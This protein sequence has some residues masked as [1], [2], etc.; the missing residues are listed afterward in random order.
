M[1]APIGETQ[2][3][4]GTPAISRQRQRVPRA[5]S[6][7][8]CLPSSAHDVFSNTTP[9]ASLPTISWGMLRRANLLLKRATPL[10][11][12]PSLP[13]CAGSK[14]TAQLCAL[15][16]IVTMVVMMIVG[17]TIVAVMAM[18]IVMM[19]TVVAIEIGV[20]PR[21]WISSPSGWSILSHGKRSSTEQQRP[22][23]D[24]S[25]LILS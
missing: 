16:L 25:V 9:K 12:T 23:L 4:A 11:N 20:Q 17:M 2:T 24:R 19:V 18:I 3:R 21:W 13:H 7:P 14:Q 22:P 5:L 1:A 6:R 8:L 10:R 15:A